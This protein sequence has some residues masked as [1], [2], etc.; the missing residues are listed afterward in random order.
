[1]MFWILNAIRISQNDPI[2]MGYISISLMFLFG[3][4]FSLNDVVKK[5]RWSI[6][7]TADRLV[8]CSGWRKTEWMWSDVRSVSLK[9][10]RNLHI[11]S[12]TSKVVLPSDMLNFQ[13]ACEQV[14]RIVGHHPLIRFNETV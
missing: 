6:T 9:V 7:I 13:I 11:K 8:L 10:G 2:S 12:E 4:C 14:R 3:F 1:L 5:N